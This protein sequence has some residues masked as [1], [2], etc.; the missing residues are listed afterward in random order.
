MIILILKTQIIILKLMIFYVIYVC[1]SVFTVGEEEE[2]ERAESR[3][4]NR[5]VGNLGTFLHF[6]INQLLHVII[7]LDMPCNSVFKRIKLSNVLRAIL[8]I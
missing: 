7:F 1:V 8:I 2:R 5:L 6:N 4:E 3:S